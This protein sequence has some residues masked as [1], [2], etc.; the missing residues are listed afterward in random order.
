MDTEQLYFTLVV[1]I[2]SSL[3]ATALF[4]SFSEIIRRFVLPWVSDKIYQGVRIDGEWHEVLESEGVAS[5]KGK[6]SL[7]QKS[8]KITGSYI[9]GEGEGKTTYAVYGTLKNMYFMATLEPTSSKMIDAG[10]MLMHVEHEKDSLRLKGSLLYQGDPGKVETW[11][12]I[13]FLQ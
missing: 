1:G 7:Y 3:I 13:E 6:L 9:H 4:I 12:G 2:S 11:E 5:T 10:A 8:T